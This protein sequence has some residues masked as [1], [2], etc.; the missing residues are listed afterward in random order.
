[1]TSK[2]RLHQLIEQ[3][4]DKELTDAELVLEALHA[5]QADPLARRLLTAPLDDE[6]E[7]DKE[8]AAVA[9][10][11]QALTDGDVIADED[12]DRELGW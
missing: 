2:E 8:R 3:L 4:P 7:S 9:E 10:A 5:H 6:P 11:R 1:M 12:L